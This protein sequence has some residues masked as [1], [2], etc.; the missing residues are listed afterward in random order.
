MG[1]KEKPAIAGGKKAITL[2]HKSLRWPIIPQEAKD[3][4][5][6]LLE[7]IP[8]QISTSPIVDEFTE[9]FR[10]Y[11][12]AKYAVPLNNGTAGLL[13]ASICLDIKPGDEVICPAYTYWATVMPAAFL[14]AKIIFAEIDPITLCLD[15]Q[16]VRKKISDKT[17]CII[18]VHVWGYPT[19]MQELMEIAQAKKIHVIEDCS[20]AHGAEYRGK[21]MGRFGDMGVYSMQGTKLIP[22]GEAGILV[23][24]NEE[25]YEKALPI[26]DYTRVSEKYLRKNSPFLK[27]AKTSSHGMKFRMSPLHAAIGLVYLERLD[28]DNAI[29][30]RGCE[31]VR[32]ILRELPG[33][34]AFEAAKHVKRV[35]FENIISYDSER[36]KLPF[37]KM[38]E[39]LKAEGAEI[40]QSRYHLL[41]Q[42]PYF[43]E[44]GTKG[45]EVP[46]T[47]RV[48]S[49]LMRIPTFFTENMELA[50]QYIRAFQRVSNYFSN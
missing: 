12:G 19:E 47:E 41:N 27:Y 25:Y 20:H 14:G 26:V 2:D 8:A 50:D 36:G 17:K 6:E 45:D 39:A 40:S 28:K 30:N 34:S 37:N 10:K 4:V 24:D 13:T 11:I 35:F 18:P 7:D 22:A 9:K 38:L 33:F 49:K 42:T 43:L 3:L 21:K 31:K 48:T 1:D 16:D 32:T 46:I 29:R 44:R 5:M 15:P 23:T